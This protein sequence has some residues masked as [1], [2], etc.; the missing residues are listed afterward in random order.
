MSNYDKSMPHP[1]V[2]RIKMLRQKMSEN[3]IDY[4]L[5]P[6]DD[7]HLSE[8]VQEADKVREYFSG[9]TGSAGTLLVSMENAYLWTDSRYFLQAQE[10][11]YGSEIVLMKSGEKNVPEVYDFVRDNIWEGQSIALDYKTISANN[12]GKLCK[13]AG[14]N[15]EVNDGS[16]IIREAFT[17]R[18]KRIFNPSYMIDDRLSGKSTREKINE[19]REIIQKKLDDVEESYT[20][21]ISDLCSIMWICNLRGS[22]VSHVPV[23]YSYM[24]IDQNTATIYLNK[25]NCDVL[26][27]EALANN[28]ILLKEYGTFYNELDNIA[29][30]V[31]FLDKD[32]NNASIFEKVRDYCE[33]KEVRDRDFI[34]K[35]I[36]ND[37]EIEGMKKAHLIDATVCISYIRRIKELVKS[38][39]ISEYDAAMM[40]DK[41]RLDVKECDD[42][43][44][45]TICGYGKN[46]AI[47]HYEATKNMCSQL[48]DSGFLLVD[49]GGHYEMGTT[50]ITRTIALGTLTDKE[51]EV[52]TI[53]L[54]S[55]L[56]LLK[57]VFRSDVRGDNLDILARQP[58]W[59]YGYSYGHG[60]GHGIGCKLS[61]HEDPI[62]ISYKNH[63]GGEF[64]PGVVV[65]DEP[66]IYIENEFG[67]RLENALL[68]KY[69]DEENELCEFES[70]TLVPFE[71]EAIL[72]NMLTAEEL[73]VLNKYHKKV[74]DMISPLLEEEDCKWLKEATCELV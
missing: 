57:A 23:A 20:Y 66:G 30:D 67:V 28:D 16:K 69:K 27:R 56:N 64:V 25:K 6:T 3:G 36:K 40:L 70:L 7:P 60:T 19:I 33:I 52:Y 35:Y 49:S 22:D 1:S 42:I 38:E 41:M 54:K 68:V 58:M 31:V 50:D 34:K 10:E 12:F 73:C 2:D 29:S 72:T 17:E 15:V 63:D 59:E 48:S 24:C 71:R 46:G 53:V 45:D 26:V 13:L 4:I 44:F 21:I 43:S 51:K 18:P 61:V 9:F 32:K 74:F 14:K 37:A 55:N 11:L 62:R 8:Y 47:V 5:I 39:K 65:S